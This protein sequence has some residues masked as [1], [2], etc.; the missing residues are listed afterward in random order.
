VSISV[1]YDPNI[2][3]LYQRFEDN[4]ELTDAEIGA[5]VRAGRIGEDDIEELAETSGGFPGVFVGKELNLGSNNVN[6]GCWE[7]PILIK[8]RQWPL[9]TPLLLGQ[10]PCPSRTGWHVRPGSPVAARHRARAVEFR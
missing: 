9:G 1:E 2:E 10:Q 7:V 3:A 6:P 4:G 8:Y 5:L